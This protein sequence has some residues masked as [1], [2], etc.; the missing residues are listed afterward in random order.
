[1]TNRRILLQLHDVFSEVF[2][3]GMCISLRLLWNSTAYCCHNNMASER[4][5]YWKHCFKL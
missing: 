5:V 4:N 3:K 2:D 1:M